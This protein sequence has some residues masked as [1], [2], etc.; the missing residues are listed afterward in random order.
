M[1]E[2]EREACARLI[3]AECERVLSKQDGRDDTVDLNL[4]MVAVLLPDLAAK[5]RARG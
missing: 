1:I 4:R 2:T 5:I 3:E